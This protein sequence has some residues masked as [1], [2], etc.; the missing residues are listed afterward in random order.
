MPSEDC[1]LNWDV[2]EHQ[3]RILKHELPSQDLWVFDELHKYDQWTNYL[4]GLFDSRK[5]DQR[6]MVT[7][8]ARLEAFRRGG[9]SLQGRYLHLRLHPFSFQELGLSTFEEMET[10]ILLGGFPEPWLSGSEVESR[11]WSNNYC[12]QFGEDIRA[13]ENVHYLGQLQKTMVFLPER[14]G[15]LLSVDS[16]RE[17]LRVSHSAITAWLNIMER[18]FY[19]FRLSPLVVS[20]TKSLRKAQKHYHFDWTLVPSEAARF[21]NFIASHLLK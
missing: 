10:L 13:L 21:E 9:D 1:Y 2:D 5:A 19:I 12:M 14:V 4:K 15:S 3:A 11:R 8:S 6:I 18:L 20:A 16:L 7:R 17:E